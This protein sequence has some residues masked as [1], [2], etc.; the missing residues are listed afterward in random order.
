MPRTYG[1]A[2]GGINHGG[3]GLTFNAWYQA[4]NRIRSA[5]PSA[6]LRFSSVFKLNTG[7]YIGLGGLLPREKWA[8]RLRVGFD[9]SNLTDARQQVRDRNGIVPNRLQ[10]DYLDAI[11]RTATIT[12]RKLF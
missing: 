10:P 11:G 6:D 7:A 5:D 4:P 12:L 1:Y 8:R 3:M 9:V 2:Y